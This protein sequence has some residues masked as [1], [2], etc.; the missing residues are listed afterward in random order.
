MNDSLKFFM[1]LLK[2]YKGAFKTKLI[3]SKLGHLFIL[4]NFKIQSKY[5]KSVQKDVKIK[6]TET[7]TQQFNNFKKNVI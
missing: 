1:Y 4:L 2:D 7:G 6:S 3:I 5:Q